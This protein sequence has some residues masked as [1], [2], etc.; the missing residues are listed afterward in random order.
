MTLRLG[1][2][3]K[4]VTLEQV[5]QMINRYVSRIDVGNHEV[6]GGDLGNISIKCDYEF[7]L[8]VSGIL[9]ELSWVAKES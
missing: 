5:Q 1:D 2:L 6:Y 8:D 7:D 9:N 3:H 4:T